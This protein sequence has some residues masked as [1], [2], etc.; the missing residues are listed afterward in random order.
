M[1]ESTMF[2]CSNIGVS[3]GKVFFKEI[4]GGFEA[5]MAVA[6]F[7][8]YQMSDEE[9]EAID[10]NPYHPDFNDNDVSGIGKSKEE[11]VQAMQKNM[12]ELADSLW[13]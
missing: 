1:A 2:A 4:D 9:L 5:R 6:L 7:G 13:H 8:S 3:G 12:S 10:F 11:A